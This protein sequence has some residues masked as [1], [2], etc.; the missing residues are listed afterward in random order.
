MTGRIMTAAAWVALAACAPAPQPIPVH[1]ETPGRTCDNADIQQFV[2][3]EATSQLGAEMLRV[4]GAA[5]V[6]WVQ[7]GMAVTMEF[8]SDR[9]TVYL[10]A[11]NR[12]ERISCS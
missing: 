11:A 5:T 8:R 3:R 6:R 10:D 9:L 2:G 12:V 1:G 4:S 7:P